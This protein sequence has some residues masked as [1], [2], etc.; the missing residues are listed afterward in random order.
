MLGAFDVILCHNVRESRE[1][2]LPDD[3]SGTRCPRYK[4]ILLLLVK[5]VAVVSLWYPL[6]QELG[7]VAVLDYIALVFEFGPEGLRMEE[8]ASS[9]LL[10]DCSGQLF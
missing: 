6:L 8:P 7:P 10:V 9:V 5:L 2:T 3:S 4:I 1:D